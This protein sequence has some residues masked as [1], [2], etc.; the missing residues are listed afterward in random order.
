MSLLSRLESRFRR[1]AVPNV[2]VI[3]IA[4][5]VLVYVAYQF[6]G[7]RPGNNPLEGIFFLPEKVVNGE[8]WR[9][10]TF[11]FYP[12]LGTSADGFTIVF[13]LFF[14]YLFYLIGATREM[15]G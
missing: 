1:Y 15:T 9:L 7:A 2:T 5:Q 14:W 3:L 10:I 4:G 8:V 11:L 6:V 12:P 13:S